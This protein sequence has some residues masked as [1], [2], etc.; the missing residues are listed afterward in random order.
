M[1]PI[2]I[3]LPD[4]FLDEEVRCDYVVTKEMKKVW[5]VMLDLLSEFDRICNKYGLQ[6]QAS[7]GTL[8]GAVRHKGFIP[9]DDDLDVQMFRDDYNKLC[10]VA[11]Q[12]FKHPYFFQS[13]KTDPFSGFFCCKLR[14]SETAA[15][16]PW[17]KHSV[18]NYNKGI[19]IDIFPVD[20]VPDNED[21]RNDFYMRVQE[22]RSSVINVGRKLGVYSQ[23]PSVIRQTLKRLLHQI[24]K[25]YRNRHLGDLINEYNELELLCSSYNDVDSRFFSMPMDTSSYS[26][27][28]YLE[29]YIESILMDFEFMKIPVARNY[30]HALQQL[31]GD[32]N[33]LII[34][35]THTALFNPEE[36]YL[37]YYK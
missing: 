13:R 16:A 19:F 10:E 37:K 34:T 11:P 27:L 28:F 23:T 29:D 18:M 9:W 4:H 35:H 36:S 8:L 2:K 22:K 5:A 12:E 30:S 14:N 21:E 6:Y 32:Y 17:E 26:K 33:K 3:S 24:L 1:L 25:P 15:I 7:W 20:I 31:Y